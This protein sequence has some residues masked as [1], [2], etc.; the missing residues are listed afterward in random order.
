MLLLSTSF[1]L[2]VGQCLSYRIALRSQQPDRQ[3][4]L[5]VPVYAY[6]EFFRRP[7]AQQT[8]QE[9]KTNILVYDPDLEVISQWIS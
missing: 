9:S 5:A 3:L 2:A 6:D 1:T 8:I 7:Y 4:Y